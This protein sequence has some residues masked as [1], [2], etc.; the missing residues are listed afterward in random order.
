MSASKAALRNFTRTLASELIGRKIRV[1][2][3]SP[4]V[5]ETP[6]FGK[7][8]LPEANAQELAQALLQQIPAKRFGR[9]EHT[10]SVAELSAF[11]HNVRLIPGQYVKPF[12]K[13]Q[14]NDYRDAEA[15]AEA[16]Q[17]PTMQ[18]VP[19]KSAEQLDLQALHRIRSRL[20]GHR[21]AVINQL[22][23]FLL[24]CGVIVPQGPARLREILPSV[25][26]QRTDVLS[27][28]M[29]RLIEEL[30]DD[31]RRLDDRVDAVTSE[32]QALARQD[33]CCRRLISVPGIGAL[34]ASAVVAAI[35]NGAAFTKGRDFGAWLGLV[36]K[37]LSTGDRT[38]LG[39]LSKRGNK[40]LRTLFIIG[41]RA[42]LA[43]PGSWAKFGLE[44]WLAAATKRLHHNVLAAALANKLARIA[45]SV[46]YHGRSFARGFEPQSVS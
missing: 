3:V 12:R 25:L 20:V 22:R 44:G 10:T 16:V 38:I 19:I 30:A 14:K 7:L 37:Q 2:A 39:R 5:I 15:I 11:G 28:R 35:G 45:W 9:P 4:G 33:E 40:Y 29:I 24:E 21:T 23:G 1:N 41:A 18:F 36:P 34:T 26:A 43:K 27:P 13:G 31:W 42:V 17:R 32:V 6:L 8:G 46:L